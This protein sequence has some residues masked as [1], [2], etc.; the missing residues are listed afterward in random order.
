MRLTPD[1]ARVLDAPRRA[2]LTADLVRAGELGAF[3]VRPTDTPWYGAD[4]RTRADADNA[5][6]R[7][8]RLLDGTLPGAGRAHRA[9]GRRDR[10]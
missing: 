7:L 6:R 2:E 3:Q 4:L 5:V 9:G 1:V 10:A 8:E